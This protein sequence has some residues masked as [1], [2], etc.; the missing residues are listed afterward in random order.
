MWIKDIFG[1]NRI[2]SRSI[3]E[4]AQSSC[5]EHLITCANF[6]SE[7]L[8]PCSKIFFLAKQHKAPL[9]MWSDSRHRRGIF[10]EEAYTIGRQLQDVN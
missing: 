6:V 2:S 3:I 5:A 1:F 9:S 8:F 10:K 4:N 7:W